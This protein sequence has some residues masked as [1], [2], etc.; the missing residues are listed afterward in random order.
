MHVARN[1]Q[2]FSTVPKFSRQI[3]TTYVVECLPQKRPLRCRQHVAIIA[4][5]E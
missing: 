5:R 4:A 1:L 2:A 3:N